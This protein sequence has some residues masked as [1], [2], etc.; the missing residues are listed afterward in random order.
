MNDLGGGLSGAG[1]SLSAAQA[2]ADEIAQA[3]GEAIADG[4]SVP[5]MA[6]VEAVIASAMSR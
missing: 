1:S 6:Q 4:A 2:V 5:D 3:G